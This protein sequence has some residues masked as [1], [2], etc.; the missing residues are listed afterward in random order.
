LDVD[1]FEY[2]GNT[3]VFYATGDQQNWGTIR[4]AMFAGPAQQFFTSYFS[5]GAPT[6]KVSAR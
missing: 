5:D 3:C 2:E 4:M 1:V 6:V